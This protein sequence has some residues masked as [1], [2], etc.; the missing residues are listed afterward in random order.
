[1]AKV[2]RHSSGE[3]R[4]LSKI[5]TSKE[6][7]RRLAIEQVNNAPIVADK[8]TIVLFKKELTLL[9]ITVLFM[10]HPEHIMNM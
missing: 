7:A 1:M 10:Y 2:F 8:A 5:E 9:L 3:S 4:I 6:R